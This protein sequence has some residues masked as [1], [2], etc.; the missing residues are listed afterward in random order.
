MLSVP[1]TIFMPKSIKKKM[2]LLQCTLT[3][4]RKR[5]EGKEGRGKER[6]EQSIPRIN[7][8]DMCVK[9]FCLKQWDQVAGGCCS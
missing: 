2:L 1:H 8:T 7:S 3:F 9:W 5:N 4:S 6:G